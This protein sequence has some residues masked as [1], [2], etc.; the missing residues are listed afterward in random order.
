MKAAQF[1][2][3]PEIA[4][5]ERNLQNEISLLTAHISEES[6]IKKP[7]LALVSNW[8]ENL[9]DYSRKR[10]SLVMVIEK[11]YPDYYA[12]KYNTQMAQF[13]DIPDIASQNGNYINYV[14]SDTV[15]Y[16]FVVNRRNQKL[17]AITVDSSFFNDIRKFRSLLSMPQSSD[18][19]SL[20]FK[21]FQDVGYRLYKKLIDPIKPYLISDIMLI[22]PDNILSYLPFE[23]IPTSEVHG[24][25][26]RY[27]DLN[28]LT[29]DFDISYTYSATFTAESEGVQKK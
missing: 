21:E 12:L 11:H 20:K 15:L 25:G 3:P 1:H 29:N 26:I 10:D 6:S 19:A 7:N 17:L 14:L 16:T 27:R 18:D 8:K 4:D 9:L 24:E 2:I 28:Y 5:I 13:K 22:S 23:T